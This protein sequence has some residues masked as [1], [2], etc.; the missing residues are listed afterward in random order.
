VTEKEAE[1][2]PGTKTKKREV[3]DSDI[4]RTWG[5]AM[6]RPYAEKLEEGTALPWVQAIRT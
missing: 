3:Q 4:T 6:L 1:I 2:G 5:A